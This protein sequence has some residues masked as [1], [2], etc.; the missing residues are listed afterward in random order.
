MHCMQTC[1][2][3]EKRISVLTVAF[4]M[5]GLN[6]QHEKE[7]T[8]VMYCLLSSFHQERD[9]LWAKEEHIQHQ[10]GFNT[11]LLRRLNRHVR[12]VS[13]V[14]LLCADCT[15][16]TETQISC[17]SLL[18]NSTQNCLFLAKSCQPN[19]WEAT[20]FRV[21]RWPTLHIVVCSHTCVG[22]QST[23]M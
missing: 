23:S 11:D 8:C 13:R 12:V 7:R 4:K 1:P 15:A 17:S 18:L 5:H 22:P 2:R 9:F 3:R 14:R 21:S 6:S 20:V 19:Q 10:I 16:V